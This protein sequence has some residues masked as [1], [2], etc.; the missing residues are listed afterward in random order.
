MSRAAFLSALDARAKGQRRRTAPL[1]RSGLSSLG[2]LFEYYKRM[3]TV[4]VLFRFSRRSDAVN[5]RAMGEA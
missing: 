5:I 4:E 2:E 3:G 1:S